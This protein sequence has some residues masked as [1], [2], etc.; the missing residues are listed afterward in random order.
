MKTLLFKTS[1]ADAL[2]SAGFSLA[3][4]SNNRPMKAHKQVALVAAMAALIGSTPEPPPEPLPRTPWE[5]GDEK[6]RKAQAK[7]ERKARR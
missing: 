3:R 2:L 4:I 1:A 7:R 5:T 6:L